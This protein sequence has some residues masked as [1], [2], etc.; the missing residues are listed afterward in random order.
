MILIG[1]S[2]LSSVG[3]N[4]VLSNFSTVQFLFVLFLPFEC[5]LMQHIYIVLTSNGK[6][7]LKL[8]KNRHF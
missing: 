8:I 3:S 2:W 7:V 4:E 1:M 6:K 5:E